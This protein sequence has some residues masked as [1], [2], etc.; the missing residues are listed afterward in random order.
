MA[1]TVTDVVGEPL[2]AAEQRLVTERR[3]IVD[4]RA[5]FRNFESRVRQIR[6]VAVV[7]STAPPAARVTEQVPESP[8]HEAVADAYRATV[9]SVPH[10]DAVYGDTFAESVASEFGPDVAAVLTGDGTFDE[11]GKRA[12]LS[13]ARRAQV[14]RD[15]FRSVL[16]TELEQL[17]DAATALGTVATEL[18]RLAA[19]DP[20]DAPPSERD[21]ALDRL[22]TLLTR[23]EDLVASRQA[24]LDDQRTSVPASRDAPD[25]AVYLYADLST[26]YPILSVA[27]DLAGRIRTHQQRLLA[28]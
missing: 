13:A 1:Q 16:E 23:C 27:T 12:V 2:D 7:E 17:A 6:P 28:A 9:M 5:A 8:R 11:R 18:D 22:G 25:F 20:G 24:T 15:E 4:E 3:Q 10:Y 21:E 26:S 14:E 19:D